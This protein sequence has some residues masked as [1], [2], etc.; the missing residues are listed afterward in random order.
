MIPKCPLPIIIS[1]DVVGEICKTN[2]LL[3]VST[4]VK[5]ISQLECL[6]PLYGRKKHVPAANWRP[7]ANPT[8]RLTIATV[9]NWHVTWPSC[10]PS[11]GLKHPT[12]GICLANDLNQKETRISV[13]FGSNNPI[14]E[15]KSCFTRQNCAQPCSQIHTATKSEN[16]IRDG[17]RTAPEQLFDIVWSL[18]GYV[19]I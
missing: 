12:N 10:T 18:C 5:N 17:Q 4:P 2:S 1:S 13:A 6:L 14:C 9:G 8:G 16:K 11:T 15:P 19:D 7:T 3:V